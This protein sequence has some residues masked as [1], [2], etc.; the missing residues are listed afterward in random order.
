MDGETSVI[1]DLSDG[2]S[3]VCVCV[4]PAGAQAHLVQQRLPFALVCLPMAPVAPS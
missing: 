2:A 3:R 4:F 1:G